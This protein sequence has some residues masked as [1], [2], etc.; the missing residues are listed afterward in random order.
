MDSTDF[1]K[2]GFPMNKS[3]LRALSKHITPSKSGDVLVLICEFVSDSVIDSAKNKK[4]SYQFVVDT[5]TAFHHIQIMK[6]LH[7]RFPDSLIEVQYINGKWVLCVDW[8]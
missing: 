6:M 5:L 1:P 3:D 4:T 7:A 2:I 8:S